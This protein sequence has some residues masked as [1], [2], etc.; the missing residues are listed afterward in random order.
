MAGQRRQANVRAYDTLLAKGEERKLRI[1]SVAQRMLA[2]NGWRSTTLAQIAREAGVTPAGLLHH[3][4]SK[5]QLLQAVLELRDTDDE[6]HADFQGDL[7]E[8]IALVADRYHRSPDLIGTY[9]VLLIENL[10]PDAPLH[11]R[12]LGRYHAATDQVAE[13]IRCGQRHGRYRADIDPALK[14]VEVIAFLN[15]METSWLLDPSIPLTKV[16]QEYARSL[17]RELTRDVAR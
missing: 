7:A 9:A 13:R 15:G 3:F 1:L 14:A 17:D 6:L 11:D 5:D 16:F 12:V 4:E 10:E 8:Q 2:R